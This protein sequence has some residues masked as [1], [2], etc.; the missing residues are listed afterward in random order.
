MNLLLAIYLIWLWQ[1]GENPV[2][3]GDR[4]TDLNIL[5][6][7]IV[8]WSAMTFIIG[9]YLYR[10]YP[11]EEI[12]KCSCGHNDWTVVHDGFQY[13]RNCGNAKVAPQIKCKHHI[14]EI[15]S[16]INV[17]KQKKPDG[18]IDPDNISNIIY[19]NRCEQC[20]RIE[21]INIKIS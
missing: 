2:I 8:L 5:I 19:V 14:D 4:N 15:I 1:H 16:E 9:I 17:Y 21:K 13:C 20:G 12:K 3:T 18:T 6:I 11:D 7:I 10:K